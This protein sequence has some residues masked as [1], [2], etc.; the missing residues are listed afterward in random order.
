MV[1]ELADTKRLRQSWWLR[2]PKQPEFQRA[3]LLQH[4][5]SIRHTGRYRSNF[6]TK[7]VNTFELSSRNWR[8][9]VGVFR[10]KIA[11]IIS[12]LAQND[13]GYVLKI[14]GEVQAFDSQKVEQY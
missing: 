6:K 9:L 2:L 7:T 3:K 4:E 14:L 13:L 5:M 10:A 11:T 12:H 8:V 1:S